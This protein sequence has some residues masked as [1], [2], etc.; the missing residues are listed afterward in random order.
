ML[1]L[2][3]LMNPL[4]Q[5][6]RRR[7]YY[8]LIPVFFKIAGHSFKGSH[9]FHFLKRLTVRGAAPASSDYLL[10][11][12]RELFELSQNHPQIKKVIFLYFK[13]GLLGSSL[14]TL[15]SFFS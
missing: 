13:M 5:S 7:N 1:I 2:I 12:I 15:L 8:S 9:H 6:E 3:E 11:R 10:S 4:A 14:S